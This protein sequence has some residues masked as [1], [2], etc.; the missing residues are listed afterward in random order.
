MTLPN[1]LRRIAPALALAVALAPALP[2]ASAAE[3][4][5]FDVTLKGLRA[6]TLR[7]DGTEGD[8]RYAVTG[9][10]ESRGLAAM[11]RKVRFDAQA[12]GAVAADGTLQPASFAEQTD[13][14]SRQSEAVIDYAGGVPQVKVALPERKARDYDVDPST[15]GG[16]VDPLTALYATLRDVDAGRECNL[17]LRMFDGRRASALTLGAPEAKDGRVTC[18]GEYRRVA[19]FS[20]KDMAEKTR[21]PF[22]LTYAPGPDG[23]MQVVEVAMDTLYGSARMERR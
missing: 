17:S 23:R 8:G 9:R 21:F 11:V 18:A 4:A 2:A 14:G 15:Q 6:A 16:T 22:R 13:T 7:I 1:A 3:P 5:V 20:P 12:S 19:G 10:L